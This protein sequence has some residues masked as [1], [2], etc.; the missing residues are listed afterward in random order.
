LD[1]ASKEYKILPNALK[2]EQLVSPPVKEEPVL[3]KKF[4]LN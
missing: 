2:E 4:L 1:K 3:K